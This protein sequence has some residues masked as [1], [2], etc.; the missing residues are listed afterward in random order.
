MQS[1]QIISR[2]V[3]ILNLLASGTA[4]ADNT[5]KALFDGK[6]LAG[7][8]AAKEQN[9][10]YWKVVEGAITGSN[11]GKK[12]PTNTYLITEKEYGDF[13][14][15]CKFRISGDHKTGLINSGI[16]YR[17][18]LVHG[19]M[20]GYQA[21]IG[22]GYWGDIYDEHR[23]GKLVRG[24][25]AELMK[26]LVEDGWNDYLIRCKEGRAQLFINGHKTADYTETN[27]GIPAKGII[28][29]QLHSGGIAKVEFKDITIKPL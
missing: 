2:T 17:S 3:A 9:A 7:W 5:T 1:L 20:T 25:T 28:G 18:A 15:R 26:T 8:K 21:D 13:G 14:L 16:Q 10:K 6:S 29:L 27:E 24:D 12:V 19:K 22:K 23:R 11:D 4:L